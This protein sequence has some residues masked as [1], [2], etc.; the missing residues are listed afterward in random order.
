MLITVARGQNIV[1]ISMKTGRGGTNN[2]MIDDVS[3]VDLEIT[4]V[5]FDSCVMVN[6]KYF[7]LYSIKSYG[8]RS[9]TFCIICATD[10]PRKK[11]FKNAK[12]RGTKLHNT[13]HRKFLSITCTEHSRT[14]CTRSM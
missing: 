8:M 6:L 4:I 2:D 5:N 11:L 13:Q 10:R 3:S 12:H 14:D 9:S 1:M 7:E